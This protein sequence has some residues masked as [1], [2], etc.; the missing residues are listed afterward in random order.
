MSH[1]TFRY[2]RRRG[3][4]VP[5]GQARQSEPLLDAAEGRGLRN[6][7]RLRVPSGDTSRRGT[8]RHQF[9][10][11]YYVLEGELQFDLDG[12]TITA[13]A[14]DLVVIPA[15]VLHTNLNA[16]V[17]DAVALMLEAQPVSTG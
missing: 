12:Q 3:L 2:L 6:I 5:S 7:R 16:G 9:D 11:F 15:G 10:Q 1:Q 14:G 4:D 8:H 17:A 13:Q